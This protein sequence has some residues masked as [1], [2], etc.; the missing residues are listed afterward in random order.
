VVDGTL[1]AGLFVLACTLQD[2]DPRTRAPVA[3]PHPASLVARDGTGVFTGWYEADGQD[4]VSVRKMP[5]GSVVLTGL[6]LRK[7]GE[8]TWAELRPLEEAN[9]FWMQWLVNQSGSGDGQ[10]RVAIWSEGECEHLARD[11]GKR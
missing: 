5:D 3:Q 4:R 7:S 1:V 6:R 11:K 2:I 8:E 10:R 9:R